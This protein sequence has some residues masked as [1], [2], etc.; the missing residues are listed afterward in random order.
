[1]RFCIAM[2]AKLVPTIPVAL[3]GDFVKQSVFIFD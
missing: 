2:G 3:G 1:M